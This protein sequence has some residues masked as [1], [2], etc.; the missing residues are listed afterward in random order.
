MM[1]TL[2]PDHHRASDKA[3]SN[4]FRRTFVSDLLDV[5]ADLSTTKGL[6]GHSSETTT[7]RHDRRGDEANKKAAQLP[8]VP[9]VRALGIEAQSSERA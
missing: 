1:A 7:G 3:T 5:G 6:A 9:Y 8:R 4:D 2:R